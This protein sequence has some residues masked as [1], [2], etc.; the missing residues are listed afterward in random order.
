MYVMLFL[1]VV[2]LTTKY[3]HQIHLGKPSVVGSDGGNVRG[4][5]GH[6]GVGFGQGDGEVI[7]VLVESVRKDGERDAVSSSSVEASVGRERNSANEIVLGT[8]EGPGGG[9]GGG[10][11]IR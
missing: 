2:L 1:N 3:T 8:C 11:Y 7:V 10:I 6:A 4:G 9:H 5:Q